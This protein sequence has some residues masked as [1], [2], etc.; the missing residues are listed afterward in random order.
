MLYISGLGFDGLVGYS[1]IAMALSRVA[2]SPVSMLMI[3]D[4]ATMAIGDKDELAKVMLML[5]SVK[6]SILNAYQLKT[7]LSR[8]KLSKLMDAETWIDA[9]T[10]ID[11]GCA[12]TLLTRNNALPKPVKPPTT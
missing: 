12:G 3:H 4:P 2:M 6:D 1:P 5:D 8:A 11:L 10:T 9:R 7:G